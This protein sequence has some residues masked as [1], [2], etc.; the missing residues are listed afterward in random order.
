MDEKPQKQARD[1]HS[2][3]SSTKHFSG[4]LH[5]L[6]PYQGSKTHQ[7]RYNCQAGEKKKDNI[8]NQLITRNTLEPQA[9]YIMDKRHGSVYVYDEMS[10]RHGDVGCVVMVR[11]GRCCLPKQFWKKGSDGAAEIKAMQKG[12]FIHFFVMKKI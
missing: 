7:A 1:C 3:C 5:H 6:M 4:F 11:N 12:D 10:R 8:V 9:I 2:V